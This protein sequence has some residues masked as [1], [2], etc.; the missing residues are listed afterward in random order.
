MTE[1]P[2]IRKGWLTYWMAYWICLLA[3][4]AFL[5]LIWIV[6]ILLF[7]YGEKRALEDNRKGDTYSEAIDLLYGGKPARIPLITGLAAYNVLAFVS[8]IGYNAGL[9]TALRSERL[10][11]LGT[12]VFSWLVFHFLLRRRYG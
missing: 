9:Y 10:I 8:L 7:F 3:G 11:V 4:E 5:G 1:Q 12:G 6:P 2:V